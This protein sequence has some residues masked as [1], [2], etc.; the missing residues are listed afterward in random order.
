MRLS[1]WR[2]KA[3]VQDSMDERVMSVLRTVLIALGADPDPD[4]WVIWGEDSQ[5][6]YSVLVPVAAGLVAVAVRTPSGAGEARAMAR[7]VRWPKLPI[8]EF[9]IDAGEE[10]RAV[11]VQL[12]SFVLKG[13]DEEADRICEFVRGL[14]IQADNRA[15]QG[16]GPELM[17]ALTEALGRL[18]APVPVAAPSGSRRR[19]AAAPRPRTRELPTGP[20]SVPASRST[21][22]ATRPKPAPRKPA[23]PEVAPAG[24]DADSAPLGEASAGVTVAAAEPDMSV[25]AEPADRPSSILV[26]VPAEDSATAAEPEPAKVT[27]RK[28]RA[29][30][31]PVA[32]PVEGAV[33]KPPR[34]RRIHREWPEPA[35]DRPGWVAP[36]A[37]A[38][39]PKKPRRWIP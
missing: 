19:S 13:S 23:E 5:T 18:A 30:R 10:R 22:A 11:A 4:C 3:P 38:P 12:E 29:P 8:G 37:P 28:P 39:D 9:S 6:R 2:T 31:K 33:A 17:R 27:P 24:P 26:L 36:R 32:E 25:A 7:L 1:E 34:P 15:G 21:R 14:V 16:V 20:A 35:A